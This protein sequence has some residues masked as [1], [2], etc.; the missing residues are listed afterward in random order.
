MSDERDLE[1]G[2]KGDHG[3]HGD[4]G[5]AGPT[6]APGIQ[7]G[8]G[9]AGLPG[10]RGPVGD[11]GAVGPQGEQ[12]KP[13]RRF[14]ANLRLL[15]FIA[16]A[17]AAIYSSGRTF[18]LARENRVILERTQT[19]QARIEAEGIER[20]HQICLGDEREHAVN[21]E[22][23]GNTYRYLAE[24]SD[25]ELEAARRGEGD[26]LNRFVLANLP[27]TEEQAAIDSAPG[28]CDEANIGLPEPDPVVPRRPERLDRY[29]PQP[30][31]TNNYNGPH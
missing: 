29:A 19:N 18:D 23:L 7:G 8:E 6:G 1:R 13:E 30:A 21:V 5:P 11:T 4:A 25:A 10:E 9:L 22:R 16:V 3:Q 31:P 24:L 15:A 17:V 20:R 26:L 28:F 14:W 27:E 12:G 2:P